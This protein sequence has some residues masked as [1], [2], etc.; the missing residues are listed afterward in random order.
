M[1]DYY[2]GVLKNYAVFEGR[3]R[4]AEYWQFALVNFI[5]V[6]VLDIVGAVVKFPFLGVLYILAVLVPS[7]AVG[8]RRL[9]DTNRSGWWILIGLVPFVGG[10]ILL[11]FT[12]LDSTPGPNQ[13][14]PNPKGVGNQPVDQYNVGY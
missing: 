11:V 14:G 8:I 12:C 1:I 9:H 7:L 2:T 3:A 13:F 4:R 10:I 5:I 6:V